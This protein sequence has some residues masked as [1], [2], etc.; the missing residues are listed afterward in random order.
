MEE[1]ELCSADGGESLKYLT[2]GKGHSQIF[3]CEQFL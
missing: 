1:F 3:V 2:A